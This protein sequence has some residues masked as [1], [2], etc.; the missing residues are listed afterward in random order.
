ML[1]SRRSRKD[2]NG[3]TDR[4]EL[5]DGSKKRQALLMKFSD[6]RG[7]DYGRGGMANGKAQQTG[8]T[9]GRTTS[10]SGGRR[11]RSRDAGRGFAEGVQKSAKQD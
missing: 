7:D 11:S 1:K 8:E 2:G 6:V 5:E 3:S 10:G 4:H 9:N